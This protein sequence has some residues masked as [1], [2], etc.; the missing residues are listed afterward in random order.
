MEHD[1]IRK[2]HRRFDAHE[3]K[4]EDAHMGDFSITTR[5]GDGGDTRLFSGEHV[6]KDTARIEALGTVDETVC[7][8]GL[9]RVFSVKPDVLDVLKRLQQDLFLVGS[10]LATMPSR[11]NALPERLDGDRADRM[12]RLCADWESRVPCP[13]DFVIPGAT[14]GGAHIDMARALARRL[15]RMTARLAHEH[16]IDNPHLLRWLNRLSD[17]LWIL[18]RAEDGHSELRRHTP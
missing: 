4:R 16:E 1:F 2:R 9:A 3:K 5:Y 18:A 15:E 7:A 12:D 6:G 8:L 11:L 10:E 17:L 14:S 13:K